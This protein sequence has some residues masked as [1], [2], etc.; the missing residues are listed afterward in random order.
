MDRRTPSSLD[1]ET[2]LHEL[3]LKNWRQSVLERDFSR[4][5][6]NAGQLARSR[7]RFW[8]WQGSLD[9]AV[10]H[11]CQGRSERAW[12]AI[13]D[14]KE[15]FRGVPGLAAPAFEMEASLWLET[16]RPRQALE[17]VRKASSET[18]LLSYFGA[19]AHAR[20]GDV[21]TA[22]SAAGSLKT[23]AA[24]REQA[25]SRHVDAE[26]HPGSAV[27]TLRDAAAGLDAGEPSSV[28]LLIRYALGA[29]LLGRGE[30]EEALVVFDDLLRVEEA[31]L[32][33]PI[34]FLRS[35]FFRARL[36]SIQGDQAGAA[37]DAATFV[38]HWGEGD[39]DRERVEEARQWVKA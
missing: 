21:D 6:A 3:A 35:L 38:S 37:A 31:I 39:F 7:D 27:E 13:E 14:A 18:P 8:R 9:L 12:E 22:A 32:H 23:S 19:L 2:L 4:G 5:L 34:P 24:P 15:C 25:L 1:Y 33:W 17:A 11:L 10:T 29:S 26:I 28:A 36:R 30:T 16:G 20:L